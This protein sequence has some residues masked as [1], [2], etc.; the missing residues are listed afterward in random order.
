MYQ[1][2]QIGNSFFRCG[3]EFDGLTVVQEK[4]TQMTNE[5]SC[6]I[7]QSLEQLRTLNTQVVKKVKILAPVKNRNI[8]LFLKNPFKKQMNETVN[9]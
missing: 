8:G 4:N 9:V 2:K 6:Q 5:K 1:L 7:I 3:Q